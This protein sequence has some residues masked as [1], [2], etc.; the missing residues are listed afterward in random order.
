MPILVTGPIIGV[1]TPDGTQNVGLH[2]VLARAHDGTLTD[3]SALRSDQRP[4]IVTALAIISHVLLRR[5]AAVA[6]DDS[7]RLAKRLC[8]RNLVR[9]PS[10]SQ[11]ARIAD[12]SFFNLFS[13][14]WVRSN[15]SILPETDHL[16]AAN[17]HVLKVVYEATPEAALY[18]LMA[19]TWRHHGGVGNPAGARSRCLT[20]LVGDGVTIA[21]EIASLSS[22]YDVMTPT[23]VGTD[24][25]ST[26]E[27]VKPHALEPALADKSAC[28]QDCI[29]VH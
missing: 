23:V 8:V 17:R 28:H 15:L 13:W 29:S 2:E 10:S 26:K 3:L 20:V 18:G 19:S 11:G 1:R 4:A 9:M 22:A 24:A 25:P 7:G 21:S 12:R 5:Y 6:S 16:M 27:S 14:V